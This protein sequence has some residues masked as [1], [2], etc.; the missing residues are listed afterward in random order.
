MTPLPLD[1]MMLAALILCILLG[2]PVS[3]TIAGVA[4]AFAFLGWWLGVMDIALLG[5]LGQRVAR[6]ALELPGE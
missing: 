3:F 6:L 2:F 4:T 1:L 5:A